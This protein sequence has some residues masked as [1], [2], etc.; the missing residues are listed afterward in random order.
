MDTQNI[1]LISQLKKELIRVIIKNNYNLLAPEVQH[2]SIQLD[3]LMLPL[4][5]TQI[6]NNC[7]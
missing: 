1:L 7:I 3:Q 4:F 5:I 6:Q 2:I